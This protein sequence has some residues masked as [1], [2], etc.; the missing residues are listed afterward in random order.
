MEPLCPAILEH[1]ALLNE[2][3]VLNFTKPKLCPLRRNM[4]STEFTPKRTLADDN[5][6]VIRKANKGSRSAV[7]VQNRSDYIKEGL[8]KLSNIKF[9]IEVKTNLSKL[10]FAH[11]FMGNL[12]EK[13]VYFYQL[14]PLIRKMFS[15]NIFLIWTSYKENWI[16]SSVI[17]TIAMTQ[18]N[19]WPRPRLL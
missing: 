1:M 12:E 9:Y 15:D 16:F 18:L 11:L 3:K 4:T 8:H 7:V 14:K 5:S 2:T 17:L 6:I 10:K 19:S 13:F